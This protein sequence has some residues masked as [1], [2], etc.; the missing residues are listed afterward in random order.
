M[1]NCRLVISI[2]QLRYFPAITRILFNNWLFS[3]A[4]WYIALVWK[5]WNF[6][7]RASLTRFW[8]VFYT[9]VARVKNA[10][11]IIIINEKTSACPNFYSLDSLGMKARQNWDVRDFDNWTGNGFIR[12]K[13][14][15]GHL[16]IAR[17]RSKK[18]SSYEQR[19]YKCR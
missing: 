1:G 17:G 12:Y 6:F 2:R 15:V 10:L 8:R 4:E 9:L 14:L 3:N 16:G 13:L 7:D 5:L 18:W 11:I 19:Q